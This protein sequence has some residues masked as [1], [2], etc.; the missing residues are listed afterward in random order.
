MTENMVMSENQVPV[1]S[2]STNSPR[3]PKKGVPAWGMLL[4]LVLFLAGVYLVARGFIAPASDNNSSI[5]DDM[6]GSVVAQNESLT[7]VLINDQ[8]ASG[9]ETVLEIRLNTQKE[10]TAFEFDLVF[11]PSQ[12]EI[13]N[14][15]LGPFLSSTGRTASLLGPVPNADGQSTK[16]GAFSFGET[17]P[18]SGEGVLMTATVRAKD[19]GATS[20]ALSNVIVTGMENTPYPVT[21]GEVQLHVN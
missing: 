19:G 8:I 12:V 13:S 1:T 2:S 21:A 18:A 3:T 9:E 15:E 4:V 7:P 20:I 16:I 5:S 10:V 14:V 6:Q 11:E 17:A